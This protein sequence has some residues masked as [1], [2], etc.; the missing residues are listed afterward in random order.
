LTNLPQTIYG[1]AL[2]DDAG[3]TLLGVMVIAEPVPLSA[4]G[5]EVNLGTVSLTFVLQPLS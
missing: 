4:V 3:T 5:Q 2:L 1:A